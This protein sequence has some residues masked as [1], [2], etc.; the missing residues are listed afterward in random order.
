[1]RRPDNRG[2]SLGEVVADE[3]KRKNVKLSTDLANGDRLSGDFA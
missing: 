2:V 1:M 3:K